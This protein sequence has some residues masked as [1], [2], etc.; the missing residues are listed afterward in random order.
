M[1]TFVVKGLHAGRGMFGKGIQNWY[2]PYSSA[3][4][5]PAFESLRTFEKE[6]HKCLFERFGRIFPVAIG[7]GMGALISRFIR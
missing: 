7:F 3:D 4:H 1:V 6:L 5:S 2:Y